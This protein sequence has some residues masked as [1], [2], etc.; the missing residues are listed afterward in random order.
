MTNITAPL[1]TRDNIDHPRLYYSA[2]S[3][4]RLAMYGQ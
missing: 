2:A 4:M 3:G 1:L